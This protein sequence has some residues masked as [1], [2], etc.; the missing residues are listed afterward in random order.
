MAITK[1]N[2]DEPMNK[3]DWATD[4]LLCQRATPGP[5][6]A[7]IHDSDSVLID[8]RS[9]DCKVWAGDKLICSL[10]AGDMLIRHPTTGIIGVSKRPGFN[11]QFIAEAREALPYWLQRVRELEKQLEIAAKEITSVPAC[12]DMCPADYDVDVECCGCTDATISDVYRCWRKRWEQKAL[13][14][15]KEG[16]NG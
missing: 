10:P 12:Y 8:G 15:L 13:A 4:Y 5:W 16:N 7:K 14:E 11:A 2:I 1:S 6:E 9:A 3:R